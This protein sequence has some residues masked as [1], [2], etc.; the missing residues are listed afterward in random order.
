[1]FINLKRLPDRL[2]LYAVVCGFSIATINFVTGSLIHRISTTSSMLF[3][4]L[5]I[6]LMGFHIMIACFMGMK[7]LCDKKQLYLA[8]IAFAFACSALLMLGT[9]GS[10]P[11]WLVCAQGRPI[12][13][14]DALIFYFF[15]NVMMAV[16]F[17]TSIVL[18][19]LRHRTTH[20]GKIHGLVL[21]GCFIL[22]AATLILSW[23]HS[24]NSP[25]LSIEF[26]DN[27]T[28]TFTPLWHN[29]VGWVLIGTWSFTL[30]LLIS[31]TRLRN[32]FWYS[33]AFF[34]TAYIF[35]LLVLLS[36]VNGNAHSWNQA[37]LFETLSTLFLILVL[38]VD[39]FI[40]YRESNERYVRSY[41]NSIRDP[42]TRLY[43][44][45]YFYDTLNQRLTKVSASQPL[46][47]IVCDLDRF[48]RIND[49]Y[50]HV[51]G[52]K[53]I[54]F[55]ASVLQNNVRQEDIAARIGGE[56]FALLLV[57]IGAN[58]ALAIAERIRLSV[59]EQHEGLPERMTISMG[60]FTTQDAHVA[61]EECV[62]RADTAMYEAKN[63]GRNRVVV[64]QA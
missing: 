59:S 8:Q 6:S 42:L 28:Y 52:D 26:I 58:E 62:K 41:Q 30:I 64:W 44:R 32:I 57:N 5:T 24:S 43:N 7:Y 10:Y 22:I 63:T 4:V 31:L 50:G 47:V 46:S 37:R 29:R 9:I 20:S 56:E 40:L 25:L 19:R 14:N 27:L 35:T 38:L 48:K 16:L 3:P 13:Q 55:A 36:T 11:D 61:A 12:N 23:V 18:Y 17:I 54:Q 2:F 53:V 45:S 15:R 51:Q 39:V 60:V 33:G 1:M 34:C 21:L 49:T